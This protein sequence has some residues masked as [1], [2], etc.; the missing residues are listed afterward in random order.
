[1]APDSV[2]Q[3]SAGRQ[4]GKT[5]RMS[6]QDGGALSAVFRTVVKHPLP[7]SPCREWFALFGLCQP[8]R[9]GET[10]SELKDAPSA[11]RPAPQDVP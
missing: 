7:I 11:P 8:R 3:A 9:V 6:V 1:M 5:C 4:L 2:R 10:E